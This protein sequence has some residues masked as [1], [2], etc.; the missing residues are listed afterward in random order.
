[1]E[2][3]S[4]EYYVAISLTIYLWEKQKLPGCVPPLLSDRTKT[5]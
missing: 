3:G 2:E 5:R 1:M 4:L